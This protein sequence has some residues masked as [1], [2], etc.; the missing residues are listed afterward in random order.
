LN[1]FHLWPTFSYV[2]P[3]FVQ[4]AAGHF[5]IGL[6][7]EQGNINGAEIGVGQGRAISRLER[8]WLVGHSMLVRPPLIG[9]PMTTGA[10]SLP[11]VA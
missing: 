8:Y 1:W 7:M 5:G 9:P 11:L 4:P 10:H 3:L 6:L 2:I